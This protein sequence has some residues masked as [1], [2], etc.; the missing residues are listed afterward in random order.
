MKA[1]AL[2]YFAAPGKRDLAGMR[3]I[4]RDDV[5]MWWPAS[6]ARQFGGEKCIRGAD[7]FVEFAGEPIDRIYRRETIRW[8]IHRM[9]VDGDFVWTHATMTALTPRDV[10]YENRYLVLMR[11]EQDRIAELWESIDTAY[12]YPVFN[13]AGPG[14]IA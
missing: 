13:A 2:A 3:A 8:Q 12:A 5:V 1:V 6:A 7:R 11:I 4:L 10:P 9:A 14:D